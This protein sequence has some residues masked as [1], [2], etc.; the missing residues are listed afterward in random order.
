MED[1]QVATKLEAETA[2]RPLWDPCAG[3]PILSQGEGLL[4][5]GAEAEYVWNAGDPLE[6]LRFLGSGTKIKGK[7][8]AIGPDPP[9]MK[10][11]VLP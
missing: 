3:E 6:H 10:A 9:G 1:T 8:T 5:N 4:Y 11:Q 2:T 7:I